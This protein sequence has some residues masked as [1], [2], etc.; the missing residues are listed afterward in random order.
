[1]KIL[2][3]DDSSVMRRI[4]INSL[5]NLIKSVEIIEAADGVLGFKRYLEN[6]DSLDL[7]LSD[8]NMPNCDGLTFLK[9]LVADGCKAPVVM[10]TTEAEKANVIMAI[11]SGAKNYITKPF[12]PETLRE[13]IEK[14]LGKKL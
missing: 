1:M 3:V 8:W 9:E 14:T 4:I 10:V 7:V 6:K 13:K 5:T 11:K 2:V 12:T